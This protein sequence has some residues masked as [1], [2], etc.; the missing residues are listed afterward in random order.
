MDAAVSATLQFAVTV[1][2]IQNVYHT[3]DVTAPNQINALK[4]AAW[5][6]CGCVA[7]LNFASKARPD[8]L[9]ACCAVLLVA[10]ASM[11][12]ATHALI[13]S[14]DILVLSLTRCV[15]SALGIV[16]A[17]SFLRL[18]LFICA[19][20]LQSNRATNELLRVTQREKTAL[21]APVN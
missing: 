5:G 7:A 17:E 21:L 9:H 13:V 10:S 11:I 12:V 3:L 18:T 20:L 8:I 1:S 16:F 6:V 14:T 15:Y 4:F 19:R 2:V